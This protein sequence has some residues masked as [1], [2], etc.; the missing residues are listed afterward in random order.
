MS[1]SIS[2]FALA[3]HCYAYYQNQSDRKGLSPSGAGHSCDADDHNIR[4]ASLAFFDFAAAF[5]SAAHEWILIVLEA[6]SAPT[7]Y[8]S[9]I[10][11]L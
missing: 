10:S 1:S 3:P 8:I 11:A 9:Y 4:F 7:W 2:I 5:P 6:A